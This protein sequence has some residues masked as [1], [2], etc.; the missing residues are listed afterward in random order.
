MAE[1]V[2][3]TEV[4]FLTLLEE[5]ALVFPDGE[6]IDPEL[7]EV[8]MPRAIKQMTFKQLKRSLIVS[9]NVVM[10][11][12]RLVDV[13]LEG[14]MRESWFACM[15]DIVEEFKIIIDALYAEV[16]ARVH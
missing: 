12:T 1:P 5:W 4:L 7:R 11:F 16:D 8:Y 14:G 10:D 13:A 15:R 3:D 9:T 6:H 2:T